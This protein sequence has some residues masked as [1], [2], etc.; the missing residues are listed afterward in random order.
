VHHSFYIDDIT[1]TC[2]NKRTSAI[3]IIETIINNAFFQE[4]G[5]LNPIMKKILLTKK[6]KVFCI[7]RQKK[8]F[9]VI[10]KIKLQVKR[11]RQDEIV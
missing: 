7:Y 2:D 10:D 6:P 5:V 1:N 9:V 8:H 11:N 4:L 3:N